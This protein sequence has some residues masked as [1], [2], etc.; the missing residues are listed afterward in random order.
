MKKASRNVTTHVQHKIIYFCI[1]YASGGFT[2]TIA[3]ITKTKL[4]TIRF[5]LLSDC[6]LKTVV[7]CIMLYS[8]YMVPYCAYCAAHVWSHFYWLYMYNMVNEYQLRLGRQRQVWFIPLAYKC[9][10]YR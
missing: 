3:F 10:V 4:V 8:M 2:P 5:D 1:I 6:T 7:Y 9:G